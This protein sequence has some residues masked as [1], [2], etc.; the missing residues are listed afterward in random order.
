M[1]IKVYSSKECGPPEDATVGQLAGLLKA[2][3]SV[4]W[5]DLNTAEP[6]EVA[7]LRDVFQFHPLAIEDTA[8]QRQR[9]KIEEY[10][11]Y[12]FAILNAVE[13]NRA[14]VRFTEID[15]FI[16]GNYIVTAHTEAQ[17][18]IEEATDRVA[19]VCERMSMS[20]GMLLYVLID[21]IVDSYL[22]I[23]DQIS[24][25]IDDLGDLVLVRPRPQSLERLF[26]L[27]RALAE[28]WRVASQQRDMF[29]ILNRDHDS[30][31]GDEH[32]R[33]YFRDVYDHL[34]RT[35]DNI[36]TFRDTLLSV[37]DLYMSSVSNRLNEQVNRLTVITMGIG[38]L[39]VITGFYGMNFE[40]TWP[41]FSAPWGVPFVLIL[42]VL[43][44]LVALFIAYRARNR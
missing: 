23:L 39:A 26:V 5:L 24:E 2:Q 25:E 11:G 13:W 31:F 28:T 27:R 21:T 7:I 29:I 9:P 41:P 19:D 40:Q 37:V 15:V 43:T 14:E 18:C 33:F 32:L 8:N 22:P 38:V 17:P 20:P 3:D 6:D 44:A 12:L 16:G 35:I 4:V 34:S 36:N 42:I 30:P 10:P 1:N